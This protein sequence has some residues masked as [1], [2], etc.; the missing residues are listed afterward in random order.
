M[1]LVIAVAVSAALLASHST[2]AQAQGNEPMKPALKK[3]FDK[4]LAD[5]GR[6]DYKA[7]AAGFAAV[8]KKVKRVDVLFAWAQST[9]LS[10]DCK[11]AL[12]L[13]RELES[14]PA[15][16]DRDRGA[17]EKGIR[18]C[19]A[20]PTAPDEEPDEP[21]PDEPEPD[22]ETETDS[23]VT[24]DSAPDRTEPT[25]VVR[26]AA[27]PWYSDGIGDS[28]LAAGVV[29][30]G[31]GVGLF[32]VSAS[33]ADA[34]DSA[35]TEADHIRFEKRA[36]S[37]RTMAVISLA[38]GGALIGGAVFRYLTRDTGEK[39]TSLAVWS[40]PSSFGVSLGGGF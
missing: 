31:F 25:T 5:F 2:P 32:M 21:E 30:T 27:T 37:R 33:D 38:A 12:T 7:A 18:K 24:T 40:S 34:A 19:G 13:Y 15:L 20:E 4:A 3:R 26:P 23:A 14:Q 36:R 6:K 28:L 39:R 16:G 35:L 17:V 22:E 8:Y 11:K 10:G 9:R 1:R 29:T